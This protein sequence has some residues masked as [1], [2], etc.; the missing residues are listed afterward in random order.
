MSNRKPDLDSSSLF[1]MT[2]K[3][4]HVIVGDETRMMLCDPCTDGANIGQGVKTNH[5]L[6]DAQEWVCGVCG[7]NAAQATMDDENTMALV[8]AT[9]RLLGQMDKS[10]RTKWVIMLMECISV[11]CG[12][13]TLREIQTWIGREI[14]NG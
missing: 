4:V 10:R 14:F 3:A 8:S 2:G 12:H 6:N 7:H 1:R 11:A 5:H 9:A 13:A